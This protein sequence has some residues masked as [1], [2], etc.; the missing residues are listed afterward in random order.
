G[1]LYLSRDPDKAREYFR[2]AWELLSRDAWLTENQP[3]R[4]ARIRKL[5]NFP[6]NERDQ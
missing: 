5:A 2:R 4:L 6:E 1:E 3:D